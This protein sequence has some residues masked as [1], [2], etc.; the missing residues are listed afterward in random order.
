MNKKKV[1]Y[2]MV[3]KTKKKMSKLYINSIFNLL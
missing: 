1:V 3:Q 2:I